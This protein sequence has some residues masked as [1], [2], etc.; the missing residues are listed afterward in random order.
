M[1]IKR[2]LETLVALGVIA[3]IFGVIWI[4]VIDV[5]HPIQPAAPME[6]G[7]VGVTTK[8]LSP[9]TV[10][11]K[12]EAFGTLQPLRRMAISLESAGRVVFVSPKWTLGGTV[13]KGDQLLCLDP[14]QAQLAVNMAEAQLSQVEA[15]AAAAKVE[16][17]G[18]LAV[19]ELSREARTV[20]RRELKRARE[21]FEKNV[22]SEQVIDLAQA[23]EIAS[24]NA[25]ELA[26][27]ANRRA[28]AAMSTAAAAAE[29]ARASLKLARDGLTRLAF[30]APFTGRLTAAP[31]EIGALLAPA[32]PV[33]LGELLD[34][35]SLLLV[36]HV[37][38][39]SL[40]RLAKGQRAV[41][42]LPS[43]GD[44]S[45]DGSVRDLGAQADPLTR[46]L[47]VEIVFSNDPALDASGEGL[48]AGLFAAAE[49]QVGTLR[50]A[51]LIH[52][53]HFVWIE[54]V[55]TAYVSSRN[56]AGE[57]V[58]EARALTL[59]LPIGE[60]FLVLEGLAQKEELLTSPLDRLAPRK[61]GEPTP[62]HRLETVVP[63]KV[64]S[65]PEGQ[66]SDDGVE[67]TVER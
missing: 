57:E 15:A 46:S 54:G 11:L 6:L 21:L 28:I 42:T 64:V 62:I 52:R 67:A 13:E 41:V 48:P 58:A 61:P 47:P 34:T 16:L 49:I 19:E 55:P 45:L 60:S 33:F 37:H 59:G 3:L 2:S 65:D 50:D 10:D 25:V 43:R 35:S 29:V 20:A 53:K 39:D 30:T 44:L 24:S 5:E 23:A 18:T 27:A 17:E 26:S 40:S 14:T 7:P 31:P 51:I 22:S 4:K 56:Q 12:V 8:A 38:E 66:G 9:Q 36:A 32:A 1:Q 63:S